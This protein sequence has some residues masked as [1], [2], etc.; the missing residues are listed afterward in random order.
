MK[1]RV[2]KKAIKPLHYVVGGILLLAI[3]FIATMYGGKE[4]MSNPI[5]EM[6]TSKGLIVIELD[7]ENA[8]NTVANFLRYVDDGFY[9]ETIF[10]RVIDGFMIQGGGFTVDGSRKETYDPIAIE[11]DNNLSN[12]RGTIA[13][14]RTNDPNSATSQFFINTVDNDF[15]NYNPANPGYTVFGKVIEG[16]DVVDQISSVQTQSA[17]MPDWPEEPITINAVKRR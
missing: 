17:P 16:M 15:L 6:Q 10:H 1:R 11:S 9:Q 7:Q 2:S 3:I 13:M 5:I 14:A 12:V 4:K 8:P